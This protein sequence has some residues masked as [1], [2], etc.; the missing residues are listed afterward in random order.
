MV[1]VMKRQEDFH[2]PLLCIEAAEI[3]MLR[4]R[5]QTDPMMELQRHKATIALLLL[6]YTRLCELRLA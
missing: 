3:C 5:G 4:R 6:S 1:A 2:R